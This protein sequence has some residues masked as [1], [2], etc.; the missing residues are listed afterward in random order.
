MLNGVLPALRDGDPRDPAPTQKDRDH[1]ARPGPGCSSGSSASLSLCGPSSS[2]SSLVV[3][4][5]A[6]QQQVSAPPTRD[7]R[8]GHFSFPQICKFPGLRR[9]GQGGLADGMSAWLGRGGRPALP[10][11]GGE[12]G[13][14]MRG[15]VSALPK[16][17]AQSVGRVVPPRRMK[18]P[19]PGREGL[20]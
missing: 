19:L 6:A 2:G 11:W 10:G 20:G 16:L 5:T 3:V 15:W 17:P 1:P 12:G 4:E 14:R 8:E 13:A 9:S 7:P 18:M